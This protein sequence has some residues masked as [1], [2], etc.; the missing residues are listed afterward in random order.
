MGPMLKSLHRGPKGG[1]DPLDPPPL[2]PLS[3]PYWVL[4]LVFEVLVF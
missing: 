1:P 4:G 2:D 3:R